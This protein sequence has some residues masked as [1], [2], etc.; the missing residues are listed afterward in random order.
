MNIL[1][2]ERGMSRDEA[3]HEALLIMERS[4]RARAAKKHA[5]G[6]NENCIP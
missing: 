3:S 4:H 5:G 6:K 1:M 2:T